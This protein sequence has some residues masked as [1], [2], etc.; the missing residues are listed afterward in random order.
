MGYD[1]HI[2]RKA[3]WHEAA[4]PAISLS[5]W[6]DYVRSDPEMQLCYAYVDDEDGK[7]QLIVA[8][9]AKWIAHPRIEECNDVGWLGHKGD[10]IFTRNPD[11]P[12]LKKMHEIAIA[13]DAKVQGDD[14]EVY[15]ADGNQVER[16]RRPPAT[17][18]KK[19]R[20]MIRTLKACKSC[21]PARLRPNCN[22]VVATP[23]PPTI[24]IHDTQPAPRVRAP[25]ER[26]C[27]TRSFCVA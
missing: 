5:E 20:Q 17:E 1:V 13:L 4:G 19:A 16:P 12:I 9:V 15:D 11:R 24:A 8:D 2:T 22:R 10:C 27:R 18:Q 6:H 26:C 3:N 23:E 25:S 14:G 21:W 7:P